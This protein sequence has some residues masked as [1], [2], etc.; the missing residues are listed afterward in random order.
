MMH[1]PDVRNPPILEDTLRAEEYKGTAREMKEDEIA[2]TPPVEKVPISANSI[3]SNSIFIS[4]PSPMSNNALNVT[5]EV[6]PNFEDALSALQLQAQHENLINMVT[7]HPTG[8]LQ[9][10]NQQT[11]FG[12]VN[13]GPGMSVISPI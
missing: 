11:D 10:A 4:L 5:N 2:F 6:P 3:F 8:V 1:G 13:V 12:Q 7:S 9:Q